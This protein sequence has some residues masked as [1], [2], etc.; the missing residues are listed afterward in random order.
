MLYLIQFLRGLRKE[1]TTK[2][3]K[4]I[5]I[6]EA[7]TIRCSCGHYPK[8]RAITNGYIQI[9][10]QVTDTGC[11]HGTIPAIEETAALAAEMWAFRQS[12]QER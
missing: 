6:E 5:T 10:C 12:Q 9:H 3:D 11:M 4:P 8:M 7:L 1:L 2:R